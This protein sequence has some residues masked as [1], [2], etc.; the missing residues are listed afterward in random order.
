[1]KNNYSLDEIIKSPLFRNTRKSLLKGE[2]EVLN[3]PHSF[4]IRQKAESESKVKRL[5]LLPPKGMTA[6]ST[7]EM[8]S[9][10]EV[11]RAKIIFKG[12]IRPDKKG[13][14]LLKKSLLFSY[15]T[16]RDIQLKG[17][18]PYAEPNKSSSFY[19]EE[20]KSAREKFWVVKEDGFGFY[21]NLINESNE[22]V[23][24]ILE[25]GLRLQKE[26]NVAKEMIGLKEEEKT[27][28]RKFFEK[29]KEHGDDLFEADK[30]I[31]EKI[32]KIAPE[33]SLPVLIEGLNILETGRHEP[34]TVF[35]TILKIGKKNRTVTSRHLQS[36]LN[37]QTAPEY[38]LSELIKK[39]ENNDKNQ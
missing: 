5:I 38:Y 17:D 26:M 14:N 32:V 39:V 34:C 24:L 23:L 2:I 35:A 13:F 27:L 18:S 19:L 12:G 16:K 28:L 29:V 3:R 1:M 9:H 25:K 21:H 20:V 7:K 6:N 33:K 22:W 4:I 15:Y 11:R 31:V 8:S 37:S 30:L 10:T 36:A